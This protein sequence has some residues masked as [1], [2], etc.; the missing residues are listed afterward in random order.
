MLMML[1]KVKVVYDVNHD[2]VGAA[3]RG[4]VA[5]KAPGMCASGHDAFPHVDDALYSQSR[6]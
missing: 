5:I 3:K 4:D 2:T 6:I 1:L